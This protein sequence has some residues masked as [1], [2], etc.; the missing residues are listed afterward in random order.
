MPFGVITSFEN[1]SRVHGFPLDSGLKGHSP[2]FKLKYLNRYHPP[3]FILAITTFIA[4]IDYFTEVRS[5]SFNLRWLL[6][7]AV[8]HFIFFQFPL[9]GV[10]RCY[11]TRDVCSLL[12]LLPVSYLLDPNITAVY[13]WKVIRWWEIMNLG[14]CTLFVC[15][16]T[17]YFLKF[18]RAASLQTMKVI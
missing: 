8:M 17:L 7:S 15:K 14:V 2:S 4:L 13:S 10:L 9:M 3:S 6:A 1:L 12:A 18:C 11:V 16:I 5:S